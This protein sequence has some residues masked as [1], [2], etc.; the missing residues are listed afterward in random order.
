MSWN[1]RVIRHKTKVGGDIEETLAIHEAYYDSKGRVWAITKHPVDVSGE[2]IE[3]LQ[4]TIGWM[5][6][7]LGHPILDSESIPEKGARNP[8]DPVLKKIAKDA[9]KKRD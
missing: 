9:K 8:G 5:R 7:A 2:S 4:T 3:D 1:H 6:K